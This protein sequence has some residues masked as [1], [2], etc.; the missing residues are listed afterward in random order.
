MSQIVEQEPGQPIRALS[1]SKQVSSGPITAGLTPS[2]P[3]ISDG[4]LAACVPGVSDTPGS[5]S[6]ALIFPRNSP[7][8]FLLIMNSPISLCPASSADIMG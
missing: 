7:S 6:P 8:Y 4:E 5:S 2:R 1:G 3:G